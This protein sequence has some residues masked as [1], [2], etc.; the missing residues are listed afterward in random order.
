M[1]PCPCES[2]RRDFIKASVLGSLAAMAA[3]GFQILARAAAPAAQPAAPSRVALTTGGER[4]D[5]AF[6]A[7]KPFEKE[8][9]RAIGQ[10]RIIIKPNNVSIDKQLAATHAETIEGI[11]EFLKSI[12]KLDNVVVAESAASGPTF[13]GF[14]NFKYTKLADR[15]PVKFLD[16]DK[17]GSELVHVFDEKDFR[18]HAVRMSKILLDRRNNFIISAARMKTHDRIVAT[19]SLKNIVVGAPIKD[20]GFGFGSSGRKGAKSDKP[21]T[22][23]SGFR[24][25][26]YN[27]FALASRL[28]PDLALIDGFEGMEGNGPVGGTPVD[29]RVCVAGLD[30]L[31]TDRVAIELMGIDF[32]NVGYLT[33]CAQANLGEADLK[34][35]EVVGEPLERHIKKYRLSDNVQSQL[36]WMKPAQG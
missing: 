24:G 12:K 16:L 33:Y 15:Y 35:I 20:D 14:D 21:I 1:H 10:R 30:W 23:G 2:N 27:L 13:T 26:N 28:H 5:L 7:L 4:A 32:A 19:L 3:G 25:I 22:H 18:P 31:A 11:L 8:L 34:K 9:S 17:E 36:I 6:R 29:H